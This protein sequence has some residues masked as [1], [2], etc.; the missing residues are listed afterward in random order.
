MNGNLMEIVAREIVHSLPKRKR[1]LY[2]Y[3]VQ[4]EDELA[5]QAASSEEFMS[6]LIQ[7]AP[8]QQAADHFQLS[9]GQFMAEMRG[10]EKE[11]Q[12]QLD[13]VLG[14]IKWFDCTDIIRPRG[15]S[16]ENR[17]YFYFSMGDL[18]S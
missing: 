3:V 14:Q 17:K 1:D 4:L 15:S 18:H 9:Y 8:H 16:P 7:N 10:I 12:Q 5:Q 13:S 2:Q 6:L 11:I